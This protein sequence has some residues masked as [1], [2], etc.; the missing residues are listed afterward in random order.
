MKRFLV[1]FLA[2]VLIISL[3][4]CQ[5][6][7]SVGE[8]EGKWQVEKKLF[9]GEEN[10]PDIPIYFVIDKTGFVSVYADEN[11]LEDGQIEILDSTHIKIVQ[12][13][14]T[15]EYEYTVNEDTLEFWHY[16]TDSRIENAESRTILKRVKE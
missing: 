5:N 3:G 1:I 6:S 4:G 12:S 8:L 2:L 16:V 14:A 10:V 13:E 7:T 9:D 11:K 15:T